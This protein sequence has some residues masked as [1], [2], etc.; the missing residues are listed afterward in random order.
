MGMRFL[1]QSTSST[2]STLPNIVNFSRLIGIISITITP[3]NT[4]ISRVDLNH[5][6]GSFPPA[7]IHLC[8][9]RHS[10]ITDDHL[11]NFYWT[12]EG[13]YRVSILASVYFLSSA[14]VCSTPQNIDI[15]P[16]ILSVRGQ[17]LIAEV[18]AQASSG[19]VLDRL[20][21]TQSTRPISPC[22]NS[23]CRRSP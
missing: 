10:Q 8:C 12:K 14:S 1:V 6:I 15:T 11:T 13:T 3:S 16:E 17:E 5:S 18:Q 9:T 2:K 22:G 7:H 21:N 19:V 20:H 4:L 23:H